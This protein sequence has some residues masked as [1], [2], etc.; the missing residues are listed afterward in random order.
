MERAEA[1]DA[2][3]LN[4]K[5]IEALAAI[6]TVLES[7]RKI[8]HLPQN[9]RNIID[10]VDAVIETAQAEIAAHAEK[11]AQL[12][13]VMRRTH[14]PSSARPTPAPEPTAELKP[15][16]AVL[17]KQYDE[18]AAELRE[19][20]A[21]STSPNVARSLPA[22]PKPQR[23]PAPRAARA[24]RSLPGSPLPV[25]SSSPFRAARLA[26][27]KYRAGSP[28]RVCDENALPNKRA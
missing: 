2:L 24:P 27:I 7:A 13:A 19:L 17:V 18:A 12:R 3:Q 11:G 15:E 26:V 23:G 20:L 4:Q 25:R 9:G 8:E 16:S 28:A 10:D 6:I 5:Q 22:S 1:R 14:S 21:P